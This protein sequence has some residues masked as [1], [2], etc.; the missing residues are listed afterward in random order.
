LAGSPVPRVSKVKGPS[1]LT[2]FGV[3][4]ALAQPSLS[5]F[6][7]SE[8]VIA[9]NTGWGTSS[10]PAQLASAAASVGAFALT[11]GSADSALIV[12]VSGG[13]YTMQL[14]GVSNSTG[15]ALAKV[16]EVP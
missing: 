1:A 14:S 13:A 10:N 16:Y 7:S 3:A 5:V 4:G 8:T 2:G 9:S 15:F 12:N 11:S 6:N